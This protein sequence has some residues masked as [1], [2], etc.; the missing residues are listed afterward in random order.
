MNLLLIV[1][2]I[3]ASYIF[4]LFLFS[5]RGDENAVI[6]NIKKILTFPFRV[7]DVIL[8][9]MTVVIFFPIVITFYIYRLEEFEENFKDIEL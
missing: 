1:V 9:C 2:A 4:T 3:L 7:I 8:M 5:S 6:R